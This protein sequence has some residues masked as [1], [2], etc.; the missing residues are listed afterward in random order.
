M[1]T[2]RGKTAIVTGGNA[3]IGFEIVRGLAQQGAQTVVLACRTLAKGEASKKRI[4]EE[5]K[6]STSVD[7]LVMRLDLD[8]F[9]CIREFVSQFLALD[10]PLHFL[11]N[12]AGRGADFVPAGQLTKD[13]FD[14]V[15]QTNYLGHFLLSSL[16]FEK[17]EKSAPSVIVNV[18]SAMHDWSSVEAH[19]KSGELSFEK[20]CKGLVKEHLRYSTS[21]F[22]Q[23][24]FTYEIQRRLRDTGV[25]SVAVH[26]GPVN[27]DMWNWVP[28]KETLRPLMKYVFMSPEQGATVALIAGVNAKESTKAKLLYFSPY[29]LLFAP[30]HVV[31]DA[32]SILSCRKPGAFQTNSAPL[33]KQERIAKECWSFSE[34]TTNTTFPK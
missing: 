29:R 19:W 22:A 4:L 30:S 9:E 15:W 14:P 2:Y 18:S 25:Q 10:V 5:L 11:F 27:T 7:I 21:K 1:S 32:L 34:M 12:N 28:M 26:P 3:G 6:E 23:I 31:N 33:T 24:L 8:S 16:L 13:G 20:A 17:L